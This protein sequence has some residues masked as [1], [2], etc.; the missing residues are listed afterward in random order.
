MPPPIPGPVRHPLQ[1]TGRAGEF[2][3]IWFVN[4]VLSVLT[5]GI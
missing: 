2:F 1:F 3:G 5:L 4:L